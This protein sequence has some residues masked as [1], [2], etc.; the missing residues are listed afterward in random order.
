MSGKMWTLG[1]KMKLGQKKKKLGCIFPLVYLNGDEFSMEQYTPSLPVVPSLL[2]YG[3]YEFGPLNASAWRWP[4]TCVPWNH[5]STRP[6]NHTHKNTEKMLQ[7][8]IGRKMEGFWLG[9][10]SFFCLSLF[11]SL[12]FF[13]LKH[14]S[15]C[16]VKKI[17]FSLG[18]QRKN[19]NN[20]QNFEKSVLMWSLVAVFWNRNIKRKSLEKGEKKMD[21][22]HVC[23]L[24]LEKGLCFF[25]VLFFYLSRTPSGTN[26]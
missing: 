18:N 17:L 12:V 5:E 8:E 22:G 25:S 6:K 1:K 16:F 4:R 24:K 14:E 10:L 3:H 2:T 21:G 9:K 23:S 19:T 11:A 13:C 7:S 15:R 26:N 20:K